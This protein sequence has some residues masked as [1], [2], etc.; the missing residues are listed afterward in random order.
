MF[1]WIVMLFCILLGGAAF[2][3]PFAGA[4]PQSGAKLHAEQCAGC[5]IARFGGDGSRIYTRPERQ[6]RSVES[7]KQR[8][9]TCNVNLGNALFPDDEA[10]LGA[11]LNQTYYRFQ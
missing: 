4:D 1:R 9:T 8:I 6:V 2:A 7:L 3:A 5:H 11:W 10:N